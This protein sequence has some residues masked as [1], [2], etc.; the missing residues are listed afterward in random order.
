MD[1]TNPPHNGPMFRKRLLDVAGG[2]FDQR[3]DPLSDWALWVKGLQGGCIFWHLES[4]LVLWFR[5]PRQYSATHSYTRN[6]AVQTVLAQDCDSWQRALK[7][8]V[9]ALTALARDASA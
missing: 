8:N 2:A 9:C 3:L 4:P 6:E 7:N 1:V 5:S